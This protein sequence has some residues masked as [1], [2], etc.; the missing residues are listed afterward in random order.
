MKFVPNAIRSTQVSRNLQDLTD[1]SISSTR[2]TVLSKSRTV[3]DKVE[4]LESQ[5]FFGESYEIFW[6]WWT[7]SHGRRYDEE[8]GKI[9]CCR[10][11][12]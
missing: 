4:V 2:N 1:V 10:E 11:K 7:G 9:R 3:T 12:A 6:N 8:S 5:P